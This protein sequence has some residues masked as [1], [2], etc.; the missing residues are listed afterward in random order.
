MLW[1]RPH[2]ATLAIDLH[3]NN[4]GQLLVVD[5]HV[6]DVHYLVSRA[7][8]LCIS[9]RSSSNMKN[10]LLSRVLTLVTPASMST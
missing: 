2:N 8:T 7:C 5:V 9:L 3:A 1:F 6:Y 10:I 4:R